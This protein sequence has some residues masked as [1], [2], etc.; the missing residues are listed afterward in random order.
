MKKNIE[1]IFKSKIDQRDIFF[2]LV[3]LFYHIDG[4]L[5][6]TNTNSRHVEMDGRE[7]KNNTWIDGCTWSGI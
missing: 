1:L 6:I 5:E 7:K 4:H 3:C 2:L